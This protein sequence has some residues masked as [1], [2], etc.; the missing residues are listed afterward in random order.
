MTACSSDD[1]SQVDDPDS[2]IDNESVISTVLKASRTSGPA[3]LAIQFS[4]IETTHENKDVNTFRELAYHFTFNDE[5]S[6][7]WKHSNKSKNSQIGGPIASHVFE[8]AGF[9]TVKVRAQDS[10]GNFNDAFVEITVTDPDKVY[11]EENTV[12]ISTNS[13]VSEAPEDALLLTDQTFWPVWESGKRYLLMSGQDFTSFG[14]INLKKVQDIQIGKNGTNA[15]PIIDEVNI[16]R[17]KPSTSDWAARVVVSD[18]N[19]Q[20]INLP[21]TSEDIYIIRGTNTSFY[22]GTTVEYYVLNGTANESQS[23]RYPSNIFMYESTNTAP[24]TSFNSWVLSNGFNMLGT[25]LANPAQHNIRPRYA[26]NTFIGHNLFYNAGSAHHNIKLHSGGILL[27][28]DEILAKDSMNSASRWIVVANNTLGDG[29]AQKNPW[30]ITFD[31]QNSISEEGVH[32]VIVEN[33]VFKFDFQVETV[34]G[35]RNLIERG[36]TSTG[37]YKTI[38]NQNVNV[39]PSDWKGPYYIDAPQILP[40]S[41]Q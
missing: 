5:A 31:P 32:D 22:V 39:L 16:E 37:D 36:N 23:M 41:P 7:V 10:E 3:P 17:G 30:S 2:S 11:I 40:D 33:N 25:E 12:V 34:F 27:K 19:S 13:H 20:A 9:Y 38:T 29:S 28:E 8:S 21:N 15:D 1:G 24:T 35:G 18:L 26:V 14:P 4:A 6:G